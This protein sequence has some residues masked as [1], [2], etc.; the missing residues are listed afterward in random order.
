MIRLCQAYVGMADTY[1]LLREYSTMP[2]SEAYARA[3]VA[4]RKAVELDDSLATSASRPGLCEWWGKWDF[5]DGEKE[6]RRAIE[7]NPKDPIAAMV[8]QCACGT[9]AISEGLEENNKAQERRSYSHSILATSLMLFNAGKKEEAIALLK[10]VERSAPEF[11]RPT[12]TS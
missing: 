2:D 6:F 11:S 8:C 7:L 9:R 3:I 1:D 4:A 12:T 10:E 5:V